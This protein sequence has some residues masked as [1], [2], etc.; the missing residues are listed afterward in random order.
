MLKQNGAA[1]SG[2]SDVVKLRKTTS[3]GR[4]DARRLKDL[5]DYSRYIKEKALTLVLKNTL[6]CVHDEALEGATCGSAGD[7]DLEGSVCGVTSDDFNKVDARVPTS[8]EIE[9][10]KQRKTMKHSSF[11]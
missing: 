8:G 1:L 3:S 6:H 2:T 9:R 4:S 11:K 7:D 10:K 5:S